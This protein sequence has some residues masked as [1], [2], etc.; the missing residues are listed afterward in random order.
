MYTL[1]TDQYG[2]KRVRVGVFKNIILNPWKLY[3][4]FG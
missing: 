1:L 4:L 2:P 3:A